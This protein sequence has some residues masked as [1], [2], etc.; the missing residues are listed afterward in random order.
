MPGIDVNALIAVARGLPSS[1]P[2]G[3]TP[4]SNPRG[5]RYRE[6]YSLNII[7][8]KH[9][10][11]DEGTYYV[12]TNPTI[13]T[14]FTLTTTAQNAFSDTTPQIYMFNGA[15][16]SIGNRIYLDYI[17][18]LVT[19]TPTAA[20]LVNYAIKLD[21]IAR[22]L[23]TDNTVLITPVNCDADTPNRSV[24]TIKVQNSAT[25]S[26]IAA[27]SPSAR[28]VARGSLGT[29]PIIGDEIVLQFGS[30][31]PISG[32]FQSAASTIPCRRVAQAPPLVVGP[33][34]SFTMHLFFSGTSSASLA[35]EFE[36]GYWER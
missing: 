30:V 6:Q 5:G 12:A 32:F 19:A 11:A 3:A 36:I 26:V 1:S 13:S 8:T 24:A 21:A 18:F 17:R 23:T 9:I 4:A 29:I 31:D 22:A 34:Q 7:P 28:L 15:T 16:A 20:T 35:A 33:T 2:D 14:G 27:A 10:L 25:A